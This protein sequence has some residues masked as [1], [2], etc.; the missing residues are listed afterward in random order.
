LI[1][2]V[3]IMTNNKANIIKEIGEFLDSDEKGM[4]I[5]G[6]HQYKK[7]I[8]AMYVINE[9][10]K[11]KRILFRTNA[12]NMVQTHL[13][14]MVK[15]QPKAGE[16]VRIDNNVYE[17]DAFTSSG[18]WQKTSG[19]VSVIIVYPI[20]AIARG[21]VKLDCIDDLFD[22]KRFDKII[23]VSWT[24]NPVN[25]YSL[26]DKYVDRKCVYDAEEEDPAYHARVI[27]SIDRK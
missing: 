13:K 25:D 1:K 3:E 24:D 4:L 27:E 9:K 17:F 5:T 11:N 22:F 23:L 12:M 6:T 14:S 8:A 2:G 20:D 10:L 15:K 21:A 18:T 7:H 19:D 16:R 26:F